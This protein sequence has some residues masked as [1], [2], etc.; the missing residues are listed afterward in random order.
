M[1]VKGIM[2]LNPDGAWAAGR[3]K[4]LADGGH[5]VFEVA[6]VQRQNLA[7]KFLEILHLFGHGLLCL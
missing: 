5:A 7:D 6:M 1:F 3:G 2:C 4:C